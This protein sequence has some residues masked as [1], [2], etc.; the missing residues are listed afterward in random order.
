MASKAPSAHSG[1]VFVLYRN[2][3]HFTVEAPHLHIA[4]VVEFKLAL[5]SQ[6]WYVVGC[7]LTREGASTIEEIVAAISQR[8]C[9]AKLLVAGNFNSNL[10]APEGHMWD[11]AIAVA[12]STEGLEDTI[13]NFIPRRKPWL[14]DGRT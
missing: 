5:G 7:Y 1:S 3:E 12:H 13:A 10:A 9:G 8:S 14:R 4:N 11:K 6:R 2:A